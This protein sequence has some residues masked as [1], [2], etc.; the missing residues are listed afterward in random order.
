[1]ALR[2]TNSLLIVMSDFY[3]AHLVGSKKVDF[4]LSFDCIEICRSVR[5]YYLWG[6][7]F[8]CITPYLKDFLEKYPELQVGF[9]LPENAIKIISE[10]I[11]L[12]IQ[13]GQLLD[14]S[15]ISRKII[16]VRLLLTASPE[17]KARYGMP[18][19]PVDLTEFRC[20][21]DMVTTYGKYGP[22]GRKTRVRRSIETHKREMIR[23]LT[24]QGIGIS[25]LS[26]FFVAYDLE[27]GNLM[28]LI[29]FEPDRVGLYAICSPQHQANSS[30]C[31]FF[32]WQVS[33]QKPRKEHP[34]LKQ[35]TRVF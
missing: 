19:E 3:K 10:V 33:L 31:V 22:I 8:C 32:D 20:L 9:E 12:I 30:A 2:L 21:V 25:F 14:S 15:L 24:L 11:D 17:F 35:S 28:V 13:I 1:M 6:L 4:R 16:D 7:I 27:S 18:K 5:G 26:E 29:E 23:D 34:K